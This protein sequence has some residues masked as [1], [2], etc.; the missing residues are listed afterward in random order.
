MRFKGEVC[1]NCYSTKRYHEASSKRK[2]DEEGLGQP[3]KR[4]TG[5]DKT[6]PSGRGQTS[7]VTYSHSQEEEVK[8]RMDEYNARMQ[9]ERSARDQ[10]TNV[11]LRYEEERRHEREDAA[12]LERIKAEV[13]GTRG[14]RVILPEEYH[15]QA[16]KDKEALTQKEVHKSL[17]IG[18]MQKTSPPS[19]KLPNTDASGKKLS[20]KLSIRKL[21]STATSKASA[22]IQYKANLTATAPASKAP[23]VAVQPL[24]T[25]TSSP[26]LTTKASTGKL[27]PAPPS[28]LHATTI[29]STKAPAHNTSASK[30]SSTVGKPLTIQHK[31][32]SSSTSAAAKP[33]TAVH[34]KTPEAGS[35]K[36]EDKDKKPNDKVRRKP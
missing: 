1:D 14:Q 3:Q 25:K 23:Q 31:T 17:G 11:Y 35:A 2:Q 19:G 26:A 28:Q 20:Q 10:L 32:G 27:G 22:G 16:R 5:H 24:K 30:S 29:S 36:K 6:E 33:V 4:S 13:Y 34:K 18:T 9:A 7:T 15:E 12:E 21:D 8:R